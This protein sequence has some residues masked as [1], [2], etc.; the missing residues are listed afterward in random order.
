MEDRGENQWTWKDQTFVISRMVT[1]FS[2]DDSNPN[3]T[4]ARRCEGDGA[5]STQSDNQEAE[6]E[7]TSTKSFQDGKKRKGGRKKR[8][9]GA[10]K[11]RRVSR[12][13]FTFNKWL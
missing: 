13:F 12:F 2:Q 11:V 5:T 7:E 9:P 8:R 10:S 6:W 1:Q 3:Q 4:Q